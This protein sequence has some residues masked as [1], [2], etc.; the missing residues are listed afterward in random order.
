MQEAVRAMLD[1]GFNQMKLH[2][3]EICTDS[4]NLASRRIPEKLGFTLEATLRE[5]RRHH[6]NPD[7]YINFCIYGLLKREYQ[8]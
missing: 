1:Y 2:R 8:G 7:R 5:E 4:E 3:I 6:L